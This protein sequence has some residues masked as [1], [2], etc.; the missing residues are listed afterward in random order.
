MVPTK[1]G[2][3]AQ[4]L[5]PDGT[6]VNDFLLL[7]GANSIHVCNA[8]SPAATASLE[9]GKAVAQQVP[10]LRTNQRRR[11][12]GVRPLLPSESWK[13]LYRCR[14]CHETLQRTFVDLGLSPLCES[15]IAVSSWPTQKRF[16]LCTSFVCEKC[17]LVQ[18]P[19]HVSAK[20][21]FEEYAY[22]LLLLGFLARPRTHLCGNHFR[23][24][25]A[26]TSNSL[27]VE[28]ASNDGYLLQYFLERNV[29]VLGIEPAKNVAQTAIEK[30]I[31]R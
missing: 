10:E 31:P 24:D 20:A 22:F 2:V 28:L 29:P 25:C 7:S 6:L 15:Y 14:Y 1:S 23:H 4:A 18:L 12:V 9:I 27:V 21:I 19:E 17:F 13:L 3:R 11:S 8:P 26:S 5:K 30:G 16:T